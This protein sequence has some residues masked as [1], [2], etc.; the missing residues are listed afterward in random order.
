MGMDVYN[1]LKRVDA[2]DLIEIFAPYMDDYL[3]ILDLKENCYRISQRA[4]KRFKLSS[5]SFHDAISKILDLVYEEDRHILADHL[6]LVLEGKKKTHN[7]HYRWLD[8]NDRPVWINCRGEVID[9]EEGK[10]HYLIGCINETGKKQRADNISGLLGDVE[11]RSFILH[12]MN[13]GI[14]GFFMHIG[15]DD[16]CTINGELGADYGEYVIKSVA[17]CIKDCLLDSQQ[18]YHLMPDEYM[19]VDFNNHTMKD[20]I[21]LRKKICNKIEKFIDNE[22]YKAVFTVS[23]GII[24]AAM[25]MDGYDVC[26]KMSDFA[27]KQARDIGKNSVYVFNRRDYELFLRKTRIIRALRNAVEN[28]FDGFEVYYQPII[29]CHSEQIIGAEALMRFSVHSDKGEERISPLEFIPLLE[30]TGLIIPVGRFLIKESVSMCKEMQQYMPGFKVNIN[31]SHI[32]IM[33]SNVI[34]DI[35]TILD[36]Y[37]LAPECL[38]VELTESGYIDMTPHFCEL[39][40]NLEKEGIQFVIDDFGTGYSNFHCISDM[41]PNYIKIDQCFTKK[42]MNNESDYE[43]LRR[44]VEMVHSLHINICIEGVE[45]KE[46]YHK[47]KEMQVDYMQ[48]YLFGKPCER[49]QFMNDQCLGS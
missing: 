15:I 25:L 17:A 37:N 38:C 18:L 48:G 29:K 41:N 16:F 3:Y 14:S 30:E 8:K 22:K 39:R 23:A 1:L 11:M 4:V 47:L 7:L 34:E 33:K 36:Y 40:K 20:A 32:Q 35:L 31:I 21:S 5:N 10:P 46:W 43:L 28:H 42:A 26:R 6:K 19:I 9:D 44:I 49:S 24:D 2:E 45:K 12:H 13:K 27:L